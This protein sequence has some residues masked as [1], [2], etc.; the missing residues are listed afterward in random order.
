MGTSASSL[1]CVSLA[2]VLRSGHQVMGTCTQLTELAKRLAVIRWRPLAC[3][4]AAP[5]AP[6]ARSAPRFGAGVKCNAVM[7]EVGRLAK[8]PTQQ[9][10]VWGLSNGAPKEGG[11]NIPRI[12]GCSKVSCSSSC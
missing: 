4:Q 5:V 9:S 10:T 2:N 8:R 6:E 11:F 3:S 1:C 12:S 7:R